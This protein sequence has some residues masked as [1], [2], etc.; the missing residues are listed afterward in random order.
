MTTNL[1]LAVVGGQVVSENGMYPADVGLRD[2]KIVDVA[3][4]GALGKAA[5]TLDANGPAGDAGCDRHS[6]ALSRSCL[7]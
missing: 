6:L 4:P 3:A 7:S 1:S 5:E 2:G